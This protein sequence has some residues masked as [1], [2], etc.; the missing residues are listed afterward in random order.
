MKELIGDNEGNGYDCVIWF[1]ILEK[2]EH[3]ANGVAFK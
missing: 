3:P 2:H 1:S